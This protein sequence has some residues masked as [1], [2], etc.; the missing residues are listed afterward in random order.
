[1]KP[2]KLLQRV[3]NLLTNDQLY[4]ADAGK[5]K[6]DLLE[7]GFPA[8]LRLV[9]ATLE[10]GAQKYEPH[11][12]RN[13]PDGMARYNRAARRHRQDRDLASNAAEKDYA[14]FSFD[15][16]SGLPHIAHEVFNLLCM[17]E[18][19]LQ[20][21]PEWKKD[22]FLAAMCDFNPPPTSHKESELG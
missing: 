11:S 22:Y 10:Y 15:K 16:E 12:W 18:L 14:V 5:A 21:V 2:V 7:M 20:E 1:M 13:V 19:Q 9:Q 3:F 17:M 6:P 8:A 4:K